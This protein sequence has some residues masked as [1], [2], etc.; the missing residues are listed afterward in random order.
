M[1]EPASL[2]CPYPDI[3]H[4]LKGEI[5]DRLS[6]LIDTMENA[7][8]G[9]AKVLLL[10][11]PVDQARLEGVQKVASTLQEEFLQLEKEFAPSG[12][13]QAL[14]RIVDGASLLNEEQFGKG[15]TYVLE[16][17]RSDH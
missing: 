7:W 13:K 8:L 3:T 14:E 4:R 1:E 10:G 6:S 15:L 2:V 12:R 5:D 16:G 9:W 17:T 11:K